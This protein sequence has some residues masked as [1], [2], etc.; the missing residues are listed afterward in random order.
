MSTLVITEPY[1][2]L[3]N[4]YLRL[5][6]LLATA[7]ETNSWLVDFSLRAD[8]FQHG[9]AASAGR[10]YFVHPAMPARGAALGIHLDRLLTSAHK[11]GWLESFAEVVRNGREGHLEHLDTPAWTEKL[12]SARLFCFPDFNYQARTWLVRHGP[13]VRHLMRPA[14]RPLERAREALEACRQHAPHVLGVH[15]RATDYHRWR[16]GSQFV[17]PEAFESQIEAYRKHRGGKIAVLI[18]SDEPK[19]KDRFSARPGC[20]SFDLDLYEDL[21]ALSL[22]DYLIGTGMSTYSAWASFVGEIPLL[23]LFPGEVPGPFTK[24]PIAFSPDFDY[25]A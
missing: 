25:R 3:G 24:A 2:R 19:I 11:R 17:P 4:R 16:Q 7:L 18:A 10:R 12:S 1:G 23:R 6:N 15:I 14:T 8:H 20:F 22:C 21:Y 5:A 13:R 9:L